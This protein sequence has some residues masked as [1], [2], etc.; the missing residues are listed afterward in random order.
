[1]NGETPGRLRVKEE[2]NAQLF[3]NF[4]TGRFQNIDSAVIISSVKAV[5]VGNCFAYAADDDS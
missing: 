4:K 1:M 3:S 2:K 5:H